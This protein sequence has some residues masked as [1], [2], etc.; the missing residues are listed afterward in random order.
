MT[1]SWNWDL[2]GEERRESNILNPSSGCLSSGF[3]CD[4]EVAG[5]QGSHRTGEI[6]IG[7]SENRVRII[8]GL[9]VL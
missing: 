7:I 2:R 8:P 9:R 3:H 4:C 5:F 6:G 1:F